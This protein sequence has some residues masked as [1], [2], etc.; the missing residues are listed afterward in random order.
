MAA[1]FSAHGWQEG[2]ALGYTVAT[3]GMVG[4]IVVGMGI[5]NWAYGRRLVKSVRPFSMKTASERRG[6]PPRNARPPAGCQ[7]VLPDSVDSLAW[8]IAVVGLAVLAGFGMLQGLKAAEVALF[9]NATT[10]IFTG[11][12]MFPLCMLG[13][14]LLRK[15]M[16]LLKVDLL[17][18]AEQLRRIS[19]A[20]L[21]FLAVAAIATIQLEVVAANWLPL[22]LMVAAGLAWTAFSVLFVSPRIFRS[23]WFERGIAEFGQATGVTATGLLLLRTVDPDNKTSAAESFAGKQLV[24]EPMMNLWV[25]VAFALVM[26][27]GWIPVFAVSLAMLA[28]WCG[29]AFALARRRRSER[30]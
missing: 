21:D 17:V 19:G 7:T 4:G 11:F 27:V 20:S 14:F 26:T 13:G 9:P 3:C 25:A 23:A 5:V 29:V 16:G 12:P 2:I 28:L 18:D 24:H 8:H 22:V 1:A 10:R 30:K 6:I 15:G